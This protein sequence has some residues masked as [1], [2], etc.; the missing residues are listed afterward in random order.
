M[1]FYLLL[2]LNLIFAACGSNV[3]NDSYSLLSGEEKFNP[4][5]QT[6]GDENCKIQS[7]PEEQDQVYTRD[8]TVI[9]VHVKSLKNK[10]SPERRK[11]II[12]GNIFAGHNKCRAEGI[13]TRFRTM[14]DGKELVITP[15]II[16]SQ[17]TKDRFCANEKEL[18]YKKVS[19][20]FDYSHGRIKTIKFINYKKMNRK[21]IYKM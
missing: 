12:S 20:S 1:K 4:C 16:Y 11:L 9:K 6:T 10:S 3:T 7:S 17:E 21:Y 14:V 13:E 15:F 5:L 18:V 8:A 2:M 19:F